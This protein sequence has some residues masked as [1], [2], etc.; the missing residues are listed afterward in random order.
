MYLL[1]GMPAIREIVDCHTGSG[2][3]PGK[4]GGIEVLNGPVLI[5]MFTTGLDEQATTQA[6]DSFRIANPSRRSG[7]GYTVDRKGYDLSCLPS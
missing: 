5:S 6:L 7:C 1:H 2:P 3:C 4:T